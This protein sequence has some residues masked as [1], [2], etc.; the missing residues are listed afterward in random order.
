MLTFIHVHII[1]KSKS[2]KKLSKIHIN[3]IL[4]LKDPQCAV[5]QKY[6]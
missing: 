1:W 3:G 4:K 6:H 2:K 5:S